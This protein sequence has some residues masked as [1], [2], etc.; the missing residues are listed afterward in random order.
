MKNPDEIK[1]EIISHYAALSFFGQKNL[2]EALKKVT[3][4][5]PFYII[6]D[7]NKHGLLQMAKTIAYCKQHSISY[8]PEKRGLEKVAFA[9]KD[10]DERGNALIGRLTI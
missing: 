10:M 2:L 6:F 8:I 7:L 5:P 1:K 9:F 4:R 3:K